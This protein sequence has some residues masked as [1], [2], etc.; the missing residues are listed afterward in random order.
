MAL[1][2]N[3]YKIFNPCV[4]F[5]P[6]ANNKGVIIPMSIPEGSTFEI[7]G[8]DMN[9]FVLRELTGDLKYQF[10]SDVFNEGFYKVGD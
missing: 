7:Y 5:D 3:K 9:G 4:A 6:E 2:I 1:V 8:I 10:N